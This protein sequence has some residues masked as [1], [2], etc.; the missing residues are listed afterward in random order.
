M[1]WPFGRKRTQGR[2][3]AGDGAFGWLKRS[4]IVQ[5]GEM[6]RRVVIDIG[7]DEVVTVYK[8]ALADGAWFNV[9]FPSGF[10]V[11]KNGDEQTEREE[12][13]G[14]ETEASVAGTANRVRGQAGRHAGVDVSTSADG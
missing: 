11:V 2:P 7:I 5:D 14:A 9:K 10:N 3:V 4:G 13:T 12:A 6:V 1:I 8:E